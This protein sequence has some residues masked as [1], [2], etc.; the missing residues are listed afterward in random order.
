MVLIVAMVFVAVLVSADPPLLKIPA[1]LKLDL[2]LK[3]EREKTRERRKRGGGS[4]SSGNKLVFERRLT[5]MDTII[6][7]FMQNRAY[8]NY[9]KYEDDEERLVQLEDYLEA[10]RGAA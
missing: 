10:K 1:K 6:T 7:M 2:N 5:I 8:Y 9:V 4:L 3:F